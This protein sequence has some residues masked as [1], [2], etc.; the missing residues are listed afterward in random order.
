MGRFDR[1]LTP[2]LQVE[3]N[4]PNYD[5]RK[6]MAAAA[7]RQERIRKSRNRQMKEA[8]QAQPVPDAEPIHLGS[9][10]QEAASQPPAAQAQPIV[11]IQL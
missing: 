2:R 5:L 7:K 4:L 1:I 10:P 9:D 8:A 11:E 3:V 6:S